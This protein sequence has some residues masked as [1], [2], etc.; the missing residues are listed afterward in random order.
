MMIYGHLG[1]EFH[2]YGQLNPNDFL[3]EALSLVQSNL[4]TSVEPEKQL[5]YKPLSNYPIYTEDWLRL[6]H[7]KR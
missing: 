3:T 7:S 5:I 1:P 4:R 6:W 2:H